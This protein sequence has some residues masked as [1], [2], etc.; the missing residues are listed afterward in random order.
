MDNIEKRILSFLRKI[1]Q[2][3][4]VLTPAKNPSDIY[5]GNVKYQASNGWEIVVFNDANTWDYIDSIQTNDGLLIDFERLDNMPKV[6]N[7]RPILKTIID[8]YRIP[9][10]R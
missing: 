7:Y 5:A 8:I 1:E 2:E 4:I 6:T 9:E 3:E 10:V